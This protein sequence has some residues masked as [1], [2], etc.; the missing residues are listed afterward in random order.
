MS[1]SSA[2]WFLKQRVRSQELLTFSFSSSLLTALRNVIC[3]LCLVSCCW[4]RGCF[5]SYLT[6][7]LWG[8]NQLTSVQQVNFSLQLGDHTWSRVWKSTWKLS[9][10]LDVWIL[11]LLL[12]VSVLMQESKSWYRAENWGRKENRLSLYRT[13]VQIHVCMYVTLEIFYLEDS[14]GR[15]LVLL[16]K[17]HVSA[18]NCNKL[19]LH[20]LNWFVK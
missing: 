4:K 7:M 18:P 1:G 20:F 11:C 12:F 13:V 6:G 9:Y 5:S 2:P 8:N 10:V 17:H 16:W 15:I 14:S 3:A 19:W